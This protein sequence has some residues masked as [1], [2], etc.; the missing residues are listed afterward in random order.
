MK[1]V[2]HIL[3]LALLGCVVAC[4]LTAS[5]AWMLGFATQTQAAVVGLQ[6]GRLALVYHAP[7]LLQPGLIIGSEPAVPS[8]RTFLLPYVVRGR[9]A[10]VSIPLYV[11]CSRPPS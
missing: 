1:A 5:T 3:A 9:R 8:A 6:G 7:S 10:M 11:P 2:V 4:S